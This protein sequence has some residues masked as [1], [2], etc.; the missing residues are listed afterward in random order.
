MIYFKFD[1]E[2]IKAIYRSE[3]QN[4]YEY[5]YWLKFFSYKHFETSPRNVDNDLIYL[6]RNRGARATGT[7]CLRKAIAC[8]RVEEMTENGFL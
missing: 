2:S 8:N 4:L 5:R 6:I 7:N 3:N 1:H